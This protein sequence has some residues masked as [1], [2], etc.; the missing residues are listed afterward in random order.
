MR[1]GSFEINLSNA[2]WALERTMSTAALG[3]KLIL[4]V[5]SGDYP[6]WGR[7][8]QFTSSYQTLCVPLIITRLLTRVWTLSTFSSSFSWRLFLII[9][10]VVC[11]C[12]LEPL[13]GQ[14]RAVFIDKYN[15][16]LLAHIFSKKMLLFFYTS[17]G[18]SLW[19][20]SY[21]HACGLNFCWLYLLCYKSS[22]FCFH[23]LYSTN[24]FSP[25]VCSV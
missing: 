21:M 17:V 16:E 18:L 5:I 4:G 20:G 9:V 11:G 25:C 6:A 3:C 22:S 8:L 14:L 7:S 23:R 2:W 24:F 13:F 19:T 1:E 10:F 12:F 15:F